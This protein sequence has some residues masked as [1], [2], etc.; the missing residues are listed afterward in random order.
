MVKK[1][2]D[3][4]TIYPG[5]ERQGTLNGSLIYRMVFRNTKG[6]EG[7]G[8]IIFPYVFPKVFHLTIVTFEQNFEDVRGLAWLVIRLC[9]Y[10]NTAQKW[11]SLQK[12]GLVFCPSNA[13]LHTTGISPPRILNYVA[14]DDVRLSIRMTCRKE[15]GIVYCIMILRRTMMNANKNLR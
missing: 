9:H 6:R 3:E 4:G 14:C 10:Y 5:F 12:T 13:E 15:Y 1:A 8:T 11:D 7:E 2:R